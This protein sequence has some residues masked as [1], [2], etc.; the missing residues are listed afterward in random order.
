MKLRNLTLL[1]CDDFYAV[2]GVSPDTLRK[3]DSPP[4][5][6]DLF[7]VRG[8][9]QELAAISGWRTAL[10]FWQAMPVASAPD[11]A[12]CDVNFE[13]DGSSPIAMSLAEIE[14]VA[15]GYS[16]PIPTG[17][18][19]FKPFAAVAR[20]LGRPIG[21]AI[22]TAD[23]GLWRVIGERTAGRIISALAAQ[24]IGEVA[25]I[26]GASLFDS[27]EEC[28]SA[29]ETFRRCWQWLDDNSGKDFSEAISVAL[30]DY[31]KK[32]VLS[33]QTK[34]RMP[35]V[36]VRP[37]CWCNLMRSMEE[38]RKNPR[39]LAE[40]LGIELIYASGQTDLIRLLSVFA[41]F[42]D[43]STTTWA[44][45]CFMTDDDT[46]AG[47]RECWDADLSARPQI[48][49]FIAALGSM[50]EVFE[51]ASKLRFGF[52]VHSMEGIR[53]QLNADQAATSVP[54]KDLVVGFMVLFQLVEWEWLKIKEWREGIQQTGWIP[55]RLELSDEHSDGLTLIQ[56][57]QELCRQITQYCQE[58]GVRDEPFHPDE[59]LEYVEYSWPFSGRRAGIDYTGAWVR[60][61]FDRLVSSG[62]LKNAP[63]DEYQMVGV[64]CRVFSVPAPSSLPRGFPWDPTLPWSM[65]GVKG[66]LRD[67]LGYGAR[68][69]P[70]SSNDDNA[71]GKKLAMAFCG[72]A[73]AKE[74][75]E[76]LDRLL[77]GEAPSWILMLLREYAQE[78]LE[79][80]STTWPS[81]LQPRA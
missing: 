50:S 9:G 66:F 68:I 41:D 65:D 13:Y 42:E 33:A 47:R 34:G 15:E 78:H 60:W 70:P 71:I 62:Q 64:R 28:P 16:R 21:L 11:L 20:T 36:L 80:D 26:A 63:D 75:R 24:E 38:Y 57:L 6:I 2:H 19:H 8:D 59:I 25:T 22:H 46:S 54:H 56:V 29:D 51:T 45:E 76:F 67:S 61:H 52:P 40:N 5:F 4:E 14:P 74:G 49:K 77:R 35:Q 43:I 32:L 7:T 37:R 48:G 10:R 3:K 23:P 79:W 17:L 39:P 55:S 72:T 73:N 53:L 1:R 58:C 30:L 31:R 18:M 44:A 12:V 27:D 69:G 81:W